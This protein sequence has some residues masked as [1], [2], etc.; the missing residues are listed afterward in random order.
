[1]VPVR[2]HPPAEWQ[3]GGGSWYFLTPSTGWR[4]GNPP[5]HIQAYLL[6]GTCEVREQALAQVLIPG[7]VLRREELPNCACGGCAGRL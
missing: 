6:H 1:M 7:L 5:P 3:G 4:S 2:E